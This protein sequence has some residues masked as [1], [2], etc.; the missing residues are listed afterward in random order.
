MAVKSAKKS[1]ANSTNTLA[2]HNSTPVLGTITLPYSS[3]R[4]ASLMS[5][6]QPLV[7]VSLAV[8]VFIK[9][10]NL[11]T[12]DMTLTYKPARLVIPSD[13][14]KWYIILYIYDVQS[15]QTKRRRFFSLP[16][17]ENFNEKKY[18]CNQTVAQINQKLAQ[19]L[20][21]DKSRQQASK[22]AE[23]NS[24]NIHTPK[25]LVSVAVMR[26]IELKKS[27]L[28][29]K[30]FEGYM[31][32]ARH[33]CSYL[34]R[35]PTQ[36]N[37]E[38]F[39]AS[40]A[41]A[42]LN[43]IIN[44]GLSNRTYNNHLLFMRTV[45][46]GGI[47]QKYWID[48]PWKL[49]PKIK[50]PIGKNIAFLPAQQKE[51]LDYAE[52]YPTLLFLIKFM[53]YTLARTNEI[54]HLQ[55]KHIGMYTA[56]KIYLPAEFSKN[57]VE[58]HIIITPGLEKEIQMHN[59]RKLNPEW[60]LFGDDKLKCGPMRMV[61]RKI[62]SKFREWVLNKLNYPIHYT[63]YSWKHTGVIAAH[64]AGIKDDDIMMQ[65]GHKDYGSFQIYL[66]SLSLYDN[67]D[68]ANKMPEI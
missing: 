9:T 64:Q 13:G 51:I 11:V 53:Y 31:Q 3:N 44:Q 62:G 47:E 46:N 65:T 59:I 35:Q 14:K 23:L 63:L 39:N 33:F 54:S 10:F 57:G 7:A 12:T 20:V 49:I 40:H 29:P 27:Q 56:N 58:R 38:S 45:F 68:F 2:A 50:T 34:L 17:S 25:L 21:S 19:G 60:Y 48:N 8:D 55:V 5:V 30:S 26:I 67:K 4:V 37:I 61:T 43:D 66:K 1:P 42:Y 52:K 22:V 28:R 6:H 24:E 41:Q 18:L 32:M 36:L 15:G 16:E